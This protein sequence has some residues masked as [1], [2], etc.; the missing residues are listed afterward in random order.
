MFGE[1][2]FHY[3][4]YPKNKP[5]NKI[6]GFAMYEKNDQYIIKDNILSFLNYDCCY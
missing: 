4:R 1:E 2:G 3:D 5:A 6:V